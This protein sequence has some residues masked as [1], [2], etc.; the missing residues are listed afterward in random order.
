[1]ENCVRNGSHS[2]QLKRVSA[3]AQVGPSNADMKKLLLVVV[4]FGL[5]IQLPLTV[6]AAPLT[7]FS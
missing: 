2:E 5:L 3:T 1:M 4:L 6:K 7:D